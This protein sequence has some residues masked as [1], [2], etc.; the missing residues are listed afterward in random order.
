MKP[1]KISE[2]VEKAI[3]EDQQGGYFAG[4]CLFFGKKGEM[5]SEDDDQSSDESS[6]ES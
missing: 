3:A 5:I 1:L 2:S 6:A 4:F